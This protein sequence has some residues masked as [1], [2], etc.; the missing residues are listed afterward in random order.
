MQENKPNYGKKSSEESR[1]KMSE[2]KKG[3]NNP[4]YKKK[5]TK[6]SRK[7]MSEAKKGEKHPMYG[8]K[9]SKE[10]REKIRIA[11]SGENGYWYGKNRSKETREKISRA[12]FDKNNPIYEKTAENSPNWKDYARVVKKGLTHNGKQKYVLKYNGKNIKYSIDKEKLKKLAD[13]INKRKSMAYGIGAF[14]ISSY[15]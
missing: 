13:K 3:E 4:M 12:M 15:R 11:L 2:A 14:R 9:R 10:T 1:K 7:K 6:E 5:H 8:K